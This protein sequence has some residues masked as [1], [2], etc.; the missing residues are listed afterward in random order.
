MAGLHHLE[1]WVADLD[2]ACSEWGWL[3][4]QTGFVLTQ[5]WPEGQS[6][7]ADGVYIT[8]TTPPRVTITGHDRR[9]PG[10]NHLAFRAGPPAALDTI[11]AEAPGHGWHP[12][13]HERYP[14]AGGP[15]HYA[16]WLENSAGFKAELVAD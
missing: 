3:L 4:G 14:F 11:M 2:Q 7:S 13:Y 6:W 16:G 12:L 9:L 10:V 1:I 8:L 5:E 15:G